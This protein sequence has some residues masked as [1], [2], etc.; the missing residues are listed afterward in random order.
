MTVEVMF[1]KVTHFLSLLC[2]LKC[3]IGLADPVVLIMRMGGGAEIEGKNFPLPSK[4]DSRYVSG[5]WK[6]LERPSPAYLAFSSHEHTVIP[7]GGRMP[8]ES[9]GGE[10]ALYTHQKKRT[11]LNRNGVTAHGGGGQ[12]TSAPTY[13]HTRTT[14]L[15]TQCKQSWE[16]GIVLVDQREIRSRDIECMSFGE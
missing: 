4:C 8:C 2:L 10:N 5:L 16:I 1:Q 15:L 11:L 3:E 7:I 9:G 6:A 12:S 13:G 14:R